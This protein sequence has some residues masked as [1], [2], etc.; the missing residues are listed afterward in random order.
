MVY[1]TWGQEGRSRPGSWSPVLSDVINLAEMCL[2]SARR[3]STLEL[4]L[5]VA[6]RKRRLRTHPK[7][8]SAADMLNDLGKSH[9]PS[10]LHHL[11]GRRAAAALATSWAV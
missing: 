9:T 10:P 4:T 1:Y 5:P 3:R 6:T 7:P 11:S 8:C 2:R